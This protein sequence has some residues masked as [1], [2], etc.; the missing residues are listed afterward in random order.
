MNV[1]IHGVESIDS[2]HTGSCSTAKHGWVTIR[3][4]ARVGA[5]CDPSGPKITPEITLFFDDMEEGFSSMME[6]MIDAY[7]G[8]A[9]DNTVLRRKVVE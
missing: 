3:P 4:M 6:A 7:D 5:E 1:S 8:W 9:Q 2:I